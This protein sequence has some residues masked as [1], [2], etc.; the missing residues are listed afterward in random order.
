LDT[1]EKR[2][3]IFRKSQKIKKKKS[4][5]YTGRKTGQDQ[6]NKGKECTKIKKE[7]KEKAILILVGRSL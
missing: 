6:E 5:K 4:W 3:K 2:K 7:E 1:H